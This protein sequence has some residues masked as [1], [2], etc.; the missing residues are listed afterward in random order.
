MLSIFTLAEAVVWLSHETGQPWTASRL[1]DVAVTHGIP[2]QAAI[3]LGVATVTVRRDSA[4]SG[5]LEDIPNHP[6]A[7]LT[8]DHVKQVWQRD[9]AETILAADIDGV[10][11]EYSQLSS[12]IR[13]TP[14]KVRISAEALKKIM[15]VAAAAGAPAAGLGHVPKLEAQ[16]AAVLREIE[17]H[18]L[19]PK[20]LP[21]NS[22]GRPGIKAE[23]K[24]KLLKQK[25]LF[26]SPRAF[27]HTWQTMRTLGE[28]AYDDEL[29]P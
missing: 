25:Q 19:R 11:G 1:F 29:A 18:D 10:L 27:E 16:V 12:P 14:D 5:Y 4:T 21:R 15:T 6:L 24:A 3:P 20:A 9:V 13:V 17:L 2:L 23:L 28:I 7:L 26:Q 8:P 22:T